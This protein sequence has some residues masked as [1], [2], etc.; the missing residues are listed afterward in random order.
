MVLGQLHR[1]RFVQIEAS[2]FG[3]SLII[4][5]HNQWNRTMASK[6]TKAP[7]L[8]SARSLHHLC[9]WW[10]PTDRSRWHLH[11]LRRV[12]PA[13]AHP[14]S[15][16]NELRRVTTLELYLQNRLKFLVVAKMVI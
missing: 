11:I 5:G 7:C 3:K 10:S 4:G 13:E 16:Q 2:F 6:N 12:K 1:T 14:P 8:F 15:L 9:F